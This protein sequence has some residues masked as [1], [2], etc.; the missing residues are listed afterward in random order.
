M[1]V[2][3]TESPSLSHIQESLID[4][5]H[6]K[7]KKHLNQ[8]I[9]TILH[10]S[11]KASD[12]SD[13]VIQR[14][15]NAKKQHCHEKNALQGLLYASN[16]MNIALV[17]LANYLYETHEKERQRMLA[18]LTTLVHSQFYHHEYVVKHK[19][20][21][22]QQIREDADA[23]EREQHVMHKYDSNVRVI[24]RAWRHSQSK[25]LFFTS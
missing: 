6:H 3:S 15:N 4:N 8:I 25:L 22:I 11:Q 1:S 16:I 9:Q 19:D 24:Q 21:T 5:I 17:Y 23:K 20:R 14:L 7:C 13:S 10:P 2:F 18:Q 12:A